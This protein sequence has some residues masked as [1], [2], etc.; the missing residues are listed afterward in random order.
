M[1]RWTVPPV[2]VTMSLVP[3]ALPPARQQPPWA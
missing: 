2:R 1:A 3:E